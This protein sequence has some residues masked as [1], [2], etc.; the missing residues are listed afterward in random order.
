MSKQDTWK[1]T[2]MH[3][4]ICMYMYVNF[5]GK[6]PRLLLYHHFVQFHQCTKANLKEWVKFDFLSVCAMSAMWFH[7]WTGL[8]TK[9]EAFKWKRASIR[10]VW[11]SSW[12]L[13][14]ASTSRDYLATAI[15]CNA[16]AQTSCNMNEL[17]NKITFKQ[18]TPSH[19]GKMSK[20]ELHFI[21]GMT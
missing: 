5:I 13:P 8:L 11:C 18:F 6:S 15:W 19:C 21:I 2:W 3:V 16:P 4:H 12:Q 9:K 1:L 14:F 17:L 10:Q 20:D 7:T